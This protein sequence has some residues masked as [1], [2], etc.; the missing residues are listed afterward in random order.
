ML[1]VCTIKRD[2]HNA[3]PCLSFDS[4]A[5]HASARGALTTKSVLI[6]VLF[7]KQ[8]F[9]IKRPNRFKL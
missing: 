3:N 8:S 9:E 1:P 2:V 6:S 5:L 7:S 4:L